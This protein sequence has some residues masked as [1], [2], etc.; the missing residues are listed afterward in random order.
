M[1]DNFDAEKI[2][3]KISNLLRLADTSRNSSDA[4][5]AAAL[6]K[7]QELMVKYNISVEEL[8][9]A[10]KEDIESV[11][12]SHADNLGY[13]VS[14]ARVI[15]KNFR[16]K[17]YVCG[18]QITFYGYHTDINLAKDAFEFAYK[19]IYRAGNR[20]CDAIRKQG[21]SALGVFNSYALGFIK[22]IESA[23]DK[24]CKALIVVTPKEVQDAYSDMIADWK[25]YSGGVR[26]DGVFS[27]IYDE[28]KSD[29]LHQFSKKSIA[30]NS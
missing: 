2:M 8:G 7:A 29:G 30:A 22:G 6:L 21:Y 18:N 14:L 10:K 1:A 19:Y 24:Q 11:G 12:C 5:A 16:C 26:T 13:R 9:D 25:T 27:D 3:L 20:K 15:S 23:F 28:G 17:F 4:E